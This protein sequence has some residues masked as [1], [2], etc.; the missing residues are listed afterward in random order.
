MIKVTKKTSP[1][2]AAKPRIMRVGARFCCAFY[3]SSLPVIFYQS[4]GGFLCFRSFWD[5]HQFYFFS[6]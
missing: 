1:L 6:S 3:A 5:L 2:H 4:L